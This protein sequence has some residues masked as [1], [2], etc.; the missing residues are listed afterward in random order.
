LTGTKQNTPGGS[1]IHFTGSTLK[2]SF[3][4]EDPSAK[5]SIIAGTWDLNPTSPAPAELKLDGPTDNEDS[6]LL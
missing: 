1:T 6:I 2:F 5:M 4:H 3:I